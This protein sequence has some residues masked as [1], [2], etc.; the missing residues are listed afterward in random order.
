MI[1]KNFENFDWTP[2][3]YISPT[4]KFIKDA[5]S[6]YGDKFD[7]SKV[8]YYS[9]TI[10]VKII[11]PKHGEFERKPY[12]FL[13][14]HNCRNCQR[15]KNRLSTDEFVKRA[16]AKHGN[17]FD[18]SK[19]DYKGGLEPI[20]ISCKK[21][22]DFTQ[23]PEQHIAGSGCPYCN[24]SRGEKDINLILKNNN[25]DFIRLKRFD[26][27][28]S[29]RGRRL[30]FDFYLPKYNMCI[31]YDGR[32]HYEPVNYFGGLESY[33]RLKLLDSIKDKYCDD[34]NI[35]LIRVSYK[36]TGYNRILS[37]LSSF[38]DLE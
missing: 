17:K 21:H 24:E 23:I 11:C 19:V 35:K 29:D 7:Y 31:E 37:Y 25:I 22:G 20:I 34:N 33:N 8:D 14:G 3:E 12:L 1:I 15:E 9:S 4:N 30:I 28:I 27:C 5:K 2:T 13:S 16:I 36:I 38:I 18:Y 32:Q 6:L 26:D 10:P